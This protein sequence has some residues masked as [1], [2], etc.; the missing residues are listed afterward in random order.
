M[1]TYR[2]TECGLDNVTIEGINPVT[3]DAGE[4]VIRIP[5]INGLHKVIAESIVRHDNSISSKELRF[6][7]TEMGMTQ[8]QMALLVHRDPQSIGRWERGEN[9]M[10]AAAEALVRAHARE[11]LDLNG[12]MTIESLSE[13]CIVSTN[14]QAI[15][16]DGSDPSEYRQIAA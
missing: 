1:G 13:K 4:E 14:V 16:I 6:L 11:V 7:R 8:S 9:P 3:D 5:N 10:E 15:I 2:Y 12:E